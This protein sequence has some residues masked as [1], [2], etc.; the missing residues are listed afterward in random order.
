MGDTLGQHLESMGNDGKLMRKSWFTGMTFGNFLGTSLQECVAEIIIW[1]MNG[2]MEITSFIIPIMI[3]IGW[4]D[5][6]HV[7]GF[8]FSFGGP[9]SWWLWIVYWHCVGHFEGDLD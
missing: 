2:M 6:T 5:T 7:F 1:M 4:K 3:L 8:H 9:T